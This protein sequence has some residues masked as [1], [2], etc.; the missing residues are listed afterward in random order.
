MDCQSILKS[1]FGLSVINLQRIW[2]GLTIQKKI[3]L[4]NTLVTTRVPL[5]GFGKFSVIPLMHELMKGRQ[6]HGKF[7][8]LGFKIFVY[9]LESL[10]FEYV[11]MC[12]KITVRTK[13][14]HIKFVKKFQTI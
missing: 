12:I 10:F 2:I 14:L 4:S 5:D 9:F 3:G 13:F 11:S 6:E 8:I 7:L 1:G